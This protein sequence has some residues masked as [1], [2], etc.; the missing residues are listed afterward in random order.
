MRL[1]GF[2]SFVVLTSVAAL[3][4]PAGSSFEVASVKPTSHST[5][6]GASFSVSGNRLTITKAN[7][8]FLIID[9][10]DID[11]VRPL[12]GPS[13]VWSEQQQYD[14]LGKAE[15]EAKRSPAEIK[16]MLQTLLADRFKLAV[17]RE[18]RD[19]SVFALVVAPK[20]PKLG[21]AKPAD[22]KPDYRMVR[23][24]ITAQPMSMARL[25]ATLRGTEVRTLVLDETGLSGQ[26]AFTLDWDDFQ[27]RREA[28]SDRPSLFTALEE[29]LGL[30]LE[31]VK[32]PIEHLVIDRAEKPSEN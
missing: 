10:Y 12:G 27:G 17:H 26:Y 30:K 21:E 25:A 22:E 1:I 4:Q 8:G 18:T 19:I 32:R 13:W 15:G 24:H 9:A 28:D 6:R 23:G 14:V 11:G 31:A 3:G 16:L 5:D 20:G 29:Q 7:L 2:N